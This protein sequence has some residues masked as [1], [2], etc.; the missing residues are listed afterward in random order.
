MTVKTDYLVIGTGLA[1]LAFALKMAK[2]GNV[3]ILSKTKSDQTNTNWAQGGIAAVYEESDSFEKHIQ[4]T[5]TAGGG[6]CREEIVKN[7]IEQAPDRI[8]DLIQWG[9]EFD[10][11][12]DKS[13]DLTREGG[14]S[15]R[16]ILHVKDYTGA[17]IQKSLLKTVHNHPNI[18]ILEN[19]FA[20]DL[21]IDKK[22]DPLI[23]TPSRVV[24]AYVFDNENKKVNPILAKVTCLASGGAGKIYLYTSNWAGATGDGI[25]MASRAGCRVSNL[26]MMQFHPTCLY[27]P[28]A[29]NFLISEAIRGEGGEL[30]NH[31]GEKFMK[32]YHKLGS[33]APR[34]AVALAIDSEIK[35]SGKECVYIDITH[36]SKEYLMDRFPVI[37]QKCTEY[38]IHMEKDPIP[39]VPA[40]HY[41][42][43]GIQIDQYGKTDLTALFAIGET[44]CSGL[45]GANR[46]A[47][48]SLLECLAFA[49]NS[50]EYIIHHKNEFPMTELEP[51]EWID[52]H[53]ED[54]DEMIMITHMWEEIRRLMWNYVGIV[55]SNK[56][57]DR[58]EHRLDNLMNEVKDYYWNFKM[59]TDI[60]ELRNLALVARLTVKSAL[61][62]KES[63]GVHYNLDY[64]EQLPEAKDTII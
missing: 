20:I 35:L 42:C 40:A 21:L 53:N 10:L 43:G 62:R 57:L 23:T 15:K 6:L 1:G 25:A 18:K 61:K 12:N 37:Y 17:A 26:E 36:K 9:V 55:R 51:T 48:N 46:L 2:H 5:L 64:P 19:H 45:H 4:D 16:R 30:I 34:D 56:R 28:D 41:L 24:G 32:K 50:S 8:Q 14:H 7:V 31:K 38:G 60:L 49:H 11:Q 52:S 59:H 27:H 44:A 3:I 63:R 29:R 33:L 13:I 54:K 22:I 47:S 58:A 39:V